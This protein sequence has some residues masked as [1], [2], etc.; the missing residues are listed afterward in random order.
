MRIIARTALVDFW[1]RHTEA[2]ARL[3]AWYRALKHCSARNYNELLQTFSTADYVPK[4][5]TVFDVGGNAYRVV[6]VIHYNTQ[7]AYIR[8]VFTHAE[9]DR[10]T[11]ENRLS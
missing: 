8:G 10:W 4:K 6:T 7:T 3:Q 9:Y 5:F 11:R 1:S 2:E